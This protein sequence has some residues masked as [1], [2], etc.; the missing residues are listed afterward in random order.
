MEELLN[1]YYELSRELDKLEAKKEVLREKIHKE[2]PEQGYKGTLADV[3]WV[4]KKKYTYSPLIAKMEQDLKNEKKLQEL[5][6]AE[7]T[8]TK[9][10]MIK[11]I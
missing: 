10:L 2:T 6:G 5:E 9:T 8:E 1:E 7:F 3:S 4:R 11:T